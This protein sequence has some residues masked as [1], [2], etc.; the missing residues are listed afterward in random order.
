MRPKTAVADDPRQRRSRDMLD[1]SA[2]PYE[3][4]PR[5]TI[6]AL[7]VPVVVQMFD[8]AAQ[9]MLPVRNPDMKK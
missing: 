6:E 8:G 1:D 5:L 7:Q 2:L 3:V 4:E 9:V